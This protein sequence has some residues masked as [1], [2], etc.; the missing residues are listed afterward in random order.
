M[1][2]GAVLAVSLCQMVRG[3]GIVAEVAPDTCRGGV[4]VDAV[5]V[6]ISALRSAVPTCKRVSRLAVREEGR[7]PRPFAVTLGAA[8]SAKL[9]EVW[10][11]MALVAVPADLFIFTFYL[12]TVYAEDVVMHPF[13]PETCPL[14]ML[15][16]SWLPVLRRMACT[17]L[18]LKLPFMD[19]LMTVN[20]LIPGKLV[21]LFR[22]AFFTPGA[23]MLPCKGEVRL[24]VMVEG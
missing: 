11:N 1:A 18:L 19:V 13:K 2:S 20:T 16:L 10:I 7:D 8:D 21:S 12:M 15:K 14:F 17:A 24:F 3:A 9:I 6:T 23:N 5:S 4:P 22:V